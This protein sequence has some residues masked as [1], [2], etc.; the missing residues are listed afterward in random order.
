MIDEAL[1]G[2]VLR[3]PMV[4]ACLYAWLAFALSSAAFGI[5]RCGL[6]ELDLH[7]SMGSKRKRYDIP[8]SS[9]QREVMSFVLTIKY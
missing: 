9:A 3:Y 2:V 5:H 1:D 6:I 4:W 7:S 8:T